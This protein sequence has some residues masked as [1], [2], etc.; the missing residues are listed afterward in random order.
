MKRLWGSLQ[1]EDRLI[2]SKKESTE[3]LTVTGRCEIRINE[4]ENEKRSIKSR[5]PEPQLRVKRFRRE[6]FLQSGLGILE[7]PENRVQR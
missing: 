2:M 4:N 7:N 1:N 6:R 3:G 5:Y